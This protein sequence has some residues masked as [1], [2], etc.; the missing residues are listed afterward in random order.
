MTPIEIRDFLL[1]CAAINYAILILW[2]G[3][4]VWA[5]DWVYRMHTRWFKLSPER[6][7]TLNYAGV[8]AYKIG[9]MLLNLVPLIAISL[10]M[11]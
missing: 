6:F 7:D 10:T 9:I 11:R 8:A 5:H 1:W 3:V 4:F 2:F